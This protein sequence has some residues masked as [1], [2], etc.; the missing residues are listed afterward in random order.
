MQKLQL[1][2]KI[3]KLNYVNKLI[4]LKIQKIYKIQKKEKVTI[5]KKLI[6]RKL[7]TNF[8]TNYNTSVF[9]P[10]KFVMN[11]W[12]WSVQVKVKMNKKTLMDLY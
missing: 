8:K 6:S 5:M 1:T 12:I 7:L 11:K 3:M 10:K 9:N 4:H 2:I